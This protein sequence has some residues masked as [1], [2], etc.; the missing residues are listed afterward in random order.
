MPLISDFKNPSFPCGYMFYLSWTAT[1]LSLLAGIL[2]LV[3]SCLGKT[4]ELE[5]YKPQVVTIDNPGFV[6]DE[7]KIPEPK[8]LQPTVRLFDNFTKYLKF[9]KGSFYGFA[10]NPS[11][12]K[13]NSSSGLLPRYDISTFR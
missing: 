11:T 7:S 6:G 10:S 12:V 9:S 2:F 8:F 3:S 1:L 4:L 13:E 5:K